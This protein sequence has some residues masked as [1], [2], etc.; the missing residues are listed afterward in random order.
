MQINKSMQ[1][2]NRCDT[3]Q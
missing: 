3:T 1:L 2:I